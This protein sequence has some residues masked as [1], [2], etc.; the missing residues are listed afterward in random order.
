MTTPQDA[1]RILTE[2]RGKPSSTDRVRDAHRAVTDALGAGREQ[3]KALATAAWVLHHRHGISKRRAVAGSGV[4]VYTVFPPP[5]APADAEQEAEI[6][7]Q[8]PDWD[9]DE[10]TRRRDT[11]AALLHTLKLLEDGAR[12][13][14]RTDIAH[15]Y[16]G[17]LD[18]RQHEITDISADLDIEASTIRGDLKAA[19]VPLRPVHRFRTATPGDASATLGEIA[20]ML[21]VPR[22]VLK[23][24]IRYWSAPERA[25][26]EQAFPA[27]GRTDDGH[28][29]PGPVRQWWQQ[30]PVVAAAPAGISLRR[31]AEQVGEPYE[32]VRSAVQQAVDKG[33]LTSEVIAADGSVN[34]AKFTAWWSR[35]KGL[36]TL[37]KLCAQVGTGIKAFRLA[38]RAAE[39]DGTFPAEARPGGGDL[40]DGPKVLAWWADRT[41]GVSLVD[42]A[43]ELGT[44]PERLRYQLRKAEGRLGTREGTGLPA[45]VRLDNGRL[46]LKAARAWWN[47]LDT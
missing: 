39:T 7:A 35:R 46:D 19:D 1:D 8:L 14:R 41:R 38:I 3:R 45:G 21:G 24:R 18:G 32:S 33:E 47:T 25:R 17:Q 20:R 43:G 34:P 37:P 23:E 4:Q 44:T 15:L 16:T 27:D 12:E 42:A 10:A 26:H 2:L 31:A 30:M 29:R 6:V 5:S 36:T 9:H 13:V 22:L 11:A 28:Y 40:Y